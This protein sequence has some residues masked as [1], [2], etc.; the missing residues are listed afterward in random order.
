[1]LHAASASRKLPLVRAP[2]ESEHEGIYPLTN[3]RRIRFC[4]F[5]VVK[6]KQTGADKNTPFVID[7]SNISLSFADNIIE[8]ITILLPQTS[9]TLFSPTIFKSSHSSFSKP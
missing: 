5:G 4:C 7:R 9:G 2:V 3:E 6:K 1:M 8:N